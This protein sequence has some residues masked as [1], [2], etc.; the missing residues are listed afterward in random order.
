M[1][2]KDKTMKKILSLVL[3]VIMLLSLAVSTSAITILGS[4]KYTGDTT[5]LKDLLYYYYIYGSKYEESDEA[6]GNIAGSDWWYGKCPGCADNAF[7]YRANGITYWRCL[8][9]TCGECGSSASTIDSWWAGTCGSCKGTA[10]YYVEGK[11]VYWR[12]VEDACGKQG[13]FNLD[14]SEIAPDASPADRCGFCNSKSISFVSAYIKGDKVYYEYYCSNCGQTSVKL[15]SGDDLGLEIGTS[16]KVTLCSTAGCAKLA[17]F[18]RYIIENDR[19]YLVYKCADGHETK[20][21]LSNDYNWGGYYP[22]D[23]YRVSVVSNYGGAYSVVGGNYAYYNE[24]KTVNITPKAGYVIEDVEVNGKSVGATSKVTFR[25]KSNTVIQVTFAKVE[26]TERHLITAT[27]TGS[28]TIVAKKNNT[29]VVSDK[30]G[31]GYSDK[32]TYVFTPADGY[33]IESVKIDGKSVGNVSHYTFQKVTDDHKIEVTFAWK[34]PYKDVSSNYSEAVKFV[35][36]NGIM[37]YYKYKNTFYGTVKVSVQDFAIA[38]AETADTAKLLDTD[39]DR[40]KWAVQKGLIDVNE[41]L[42]TACTV[43][44]ASEMVDVYLETLEDER[45]IDY[46]LFDADASVKDNAIN[47]KLVTAAIFSK[48]RELNRYDLAAVCRLV[49]NLKYE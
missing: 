2:R 11:T 17:Y 49:A 9:D 27:Y 10:F 35:T 3:A 1:Q 6:N 26:T 21:V 4:D 31:M 43:Q 44:R 45:K 14:G 30:V 40:F 19:I 39:V 18:D 8:S 38:L 42:M 25:V 48:N 37:S 29:Y 47:I 34:S 22:T 7:F 28:G 32:I 46:T 15:V 13:A 24:L 33:E 5:S 41:S 36:E 16:A 12:C 20:R 23:A